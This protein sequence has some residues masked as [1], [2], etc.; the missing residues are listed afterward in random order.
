MANSK[1]QELKDSYVSGIIDAMS[2]NSTGNIDP[3]ASGQLGLEQGQLSGIVFDLKNGSVLRKNDGIPKAVI[4]GANMTVIEGAAVASPIPNR[5]YG[6]KDSRRLTNEEMASMAQGLYA[7]GY[8]VDN[9]REW[10]G[11]ESFY[12]D[13]MQRLATPAHIRGHY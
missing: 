6:A 4:N 13:A 7:K 3:A 9:L 8:Q 11:A 1:A 2:N 10:E 5:G 12:R